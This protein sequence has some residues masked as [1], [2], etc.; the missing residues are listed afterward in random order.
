MVLAQVRIQSSAVL[1]LRSVGRDGK[2]N[3]KMRWSSQKRKGQLKRSRA[4]RYYSLTQFCARSGNQ[5]GLIWV[6]R[7][8]TRGEE[9]SELQ[10]GHGR[11]SG[12][13][14]TVGL[15]LRGGDR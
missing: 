6:S 8:G 14:G 7:M 10:S 12:T 11:S 15:G 2:V 3:R 13:V 1:F 4:S 9:D 5:A